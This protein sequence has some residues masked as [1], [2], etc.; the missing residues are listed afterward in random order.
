MRFPVK[1]VLG[2]MQLNLAQG[3]NYASLQS[4]AG[5]DET[6]DFG[7]VA[8]QVN[9]FQRNWSPCQRLLRGF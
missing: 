9:D 8:Y 2:G 4:R 1:C 6:Y 5:G 3:G 7:P